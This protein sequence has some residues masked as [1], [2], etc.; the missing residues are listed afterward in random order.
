MR[1]R[2][3]DARA[4]VRAF[5]PV[6]LAQMESA[7]WIGYYRRE[8]GRV[9]AASVGLVRCGFRL[10]WPQTLWGAWLVLRANQ[11]WAPYP[12]NDADGARELM[13]GFYQ[14]AGGGGEGF[15]PAKAARLEVEWWRVHRELQHDVARGEDELG[16]A[17]AALYAYT[18]GTP[19]ANVRESGQL[20]ADAMR[21]CDRWV[22]NGCDLN[23]PLVAG[24]RRCLLRSYR[25][26]KAAV[27]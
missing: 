8:W 24:M 13:T 5:N 10:P 11:L 4:S 26:L 27:A 17:V 14:L 15:D 2:K 9:L 16:K 21:L 12:D 6:D 22:A 3:R 18:Y 23:D 7:A 1:F 20:R 19:I 25:S